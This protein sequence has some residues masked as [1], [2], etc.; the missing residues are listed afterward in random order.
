MFV[1]NLYQ[2]FQVVIP[3][4]DNFRSKIYSVDLVAKA[5]KVTENLS[6]ENYFLA[7]VFTLSCL[8]YDSV[9]YIFIKTSL[10][11]VYFAHS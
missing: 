10:R 1:I 4:R 9:I 2:Y 3:R 8:I 5:C 6:K 7:P 11:H